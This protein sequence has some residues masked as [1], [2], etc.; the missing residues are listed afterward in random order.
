MP[1][2]P[3][4]PQRPAPPPPPQPAAPPRSNLLQGAA[5]AQG[6]SV[7]GR[8]KGVMLVVTLALLAVA[9]FFVN[10]MVL[11]TLR[12][13]GITPTGWTAFLLNNAWI[14]PLLCLPAFAAVVPL[15]RGAKR[16]FYWMTISTLLALLPLAAFLGGALGGIIAIYEHALSL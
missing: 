3:P 4:P 1:P 7:V 6:F 8:V 11:H 5:L 2:P 12:D 16:P 15:L 14:T 9:S 10:P 13:Q